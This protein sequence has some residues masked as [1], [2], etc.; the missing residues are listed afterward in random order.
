M[1]IEVNNQKLY[2][3]SV[4]ALEDKQPVYVQFP[5]DAMPAQWGVVDVDRGI[6]IHK[7]LTIRFTDRCKYFALAKGEKKK[8][9]NEEV[10][11]II[12]MIF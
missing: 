9:S 6:T 5:N 8:E 4:K 1:T 12:K 3:V 7:D 11:N 10:N 2:E